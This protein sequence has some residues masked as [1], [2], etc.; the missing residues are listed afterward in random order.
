MKPESNNLHFISRGNVRAQ[1]ATNEGFMWMKVSTVNIGLRSDRD[2][3]V[4]YDNT[5]YLQLCLRDS[6]N[7][8]RTSA[9]ECVWLES[10]HSLDLHGLLSRGKETHFSIETGVPPVVKRTKD[11]SSASRVDILSPIRHSCC[12]GYPVI[13][14]SR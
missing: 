12:E 4:T 5:R 3:N 13:R 7:D 1:S 10:S 2:C 14:S 9:K 8:L 6:S 11:L